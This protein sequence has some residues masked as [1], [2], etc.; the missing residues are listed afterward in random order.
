MGVVIEGHQS[1]LGFSQMLSSFSFS[2]CIKRVS[3]LALFHKKKTATIPL[4]S[5]YSV[6]GLQKSLG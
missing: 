1:V 4:K 5:C 3:L 2:L 6:K